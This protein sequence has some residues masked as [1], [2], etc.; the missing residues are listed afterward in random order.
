MR[1]I[2]FAVLISIYLLPVRLAGQSNLPLGGWQA[3]TAYNQGKSVVKGGEIIYATS[4]NGLFF[5]DLSTNEIQTLSTVDG[6]S[7]VEFGPIEFLDT[8]GMLLISYEDGTLDFWKPSEIITFSAIKN[9][10]IVGD[11]RIS[12]IND[13]QSLV[14]IS[15]G[16]GVVVLDTERLEVEESYLRLGIDGSTLPINQSAFSADSIYLATP[17]GILSACLGLETNREDFNNWQRIQLNENPVGA[18]SRFDD[19]VVAASVGDSLYHLTSSGWENTGIPSG[20]DIRQLVT[21]GSVLYLIN[22]EGIFQID[23]NFESVKMEYNGIDHPMGI[24]V[25]NDVSWITDSNKGLSR[26]ES[27]NSIFILPNGPL[28]NQIEA[29]NTIF[30][31][32]QLVYGSIGFNN[33]PARIPANFSI[34]KSGSWTNFNS[35]EFSPGVQDLLN[36]TYDNVRQ[37]YYFSAYGHGILSWDGTDEFVVFDENS[38]GSTLKNLSASDDFTLVTDITTD[39]NGNLW[40]AARDTGTTSIHF[41]NATDNWAIFSFDL[42]GNPQPQAIHYGLFGDLWITLE[43]AGLLVY[44]PETGA[45]R[46]LTDEAGQ[47]GLPSNTINALAEDSNGQIWM[48]TANGVASFPFTFNIIANNPIDAFLPIIDGRQLFS[49]EVVNAVAVDPGN[50]KIF[51]TNNGCFIFDENVSELVDQFNPDNSPV[52]SNMIMD[53]AVEPASG[54]IFILTDQGLISTRQDASEPSAE[55]TNVRIFPNPVRPDFSGIIG[56]TGLVNEAVVKIT[57]IS[58]KLIIELRSNGGTSSWDGRN[59]QGEKASTGI[60]LVFSSSPDGAE[61]FIGKLAIIE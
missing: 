59:L 38:P 49:G 4:E 27:A 24:W 46:Q 19:K 44:D 29:I 12:H 53:I 55:H 8:P 23:H 52:F 47:G 25:E 13:Q 7:S 39:P 9:A 28:N 16:I 15:T 2:P 5:L 56:I 48:A 50:R 26:N 33:N 36:T 57:D 42:P 20:Q 30:N 11:K 54:E 43:D 18:V 45:S 37:Q 35:D 17:M 6:L 40:I 10:S 58:G 31:E 61:T 51:G 22:E 41:F 21:F 32:V 34:F 3:H 14:Y 60:Y 1:L